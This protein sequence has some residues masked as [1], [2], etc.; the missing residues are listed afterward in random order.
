MSRLLFIFLS[1]YLQ[2][3]I[4]QPE[5]LWSIKNSKSNIIFKEKKRRAMN[6]FLPGLRNKKEMSSLQEDWR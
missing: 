6:H 4:I 5:I 2:V 3:Y 1:N